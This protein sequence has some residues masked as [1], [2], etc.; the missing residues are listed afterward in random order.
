MA[1]N[2][3]RGPLYTEKKENLL[4]HQKWACNSHFCEPNFQEIRL[5][6]WRKELF[7]HCGDEW[8]GL[9]PSWMGLTHGN[10][11]FDILEP[12]AFQKYSICWVFQAFFCSTFFYMYFAIQPRPAL[13]LL[14]SS[15]T[16]VNMSH[17]GYQ[18]HHLWSR[19][20]ALNCTVPTSFFSSYVFLN[21]AIILVRCKKY[22]PDPEETLISCE[23]F[24]FCVVISQ[25]L[26]NTEWR[27]N[28]SKET[29]T[30]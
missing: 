11:I 9:G 20:T 28:D 15:E 4:L 6:W 19:N 16:L 29:L 12:S 1:Q 21:K 30:S 24:W 18:N 3:P 17:H 2:M 23:R 25:F 13:K 8:N 22:R 27:K 26:T 14:N 5:K 7:W 10:V